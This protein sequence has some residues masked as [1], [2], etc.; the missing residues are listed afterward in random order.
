[1][2]EWQPMETA[3]RDGTAIQAEIPGNGADNIIAWTPGFVT[4]GGDECSCW[5]I[6]EDQEP[7]SCWTDGVCW[8]VNADGVASVQPTRWKPLGE[9]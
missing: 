5:V 9:R 8:E 4:S 6:A 7:P 3:P 1:M 2:D